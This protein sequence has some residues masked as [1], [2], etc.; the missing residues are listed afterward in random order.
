[1]VSILVCVFNA[2]YLLHYLS[3]FVAFYIDKINHIL[4]VSIMPKKHTQS[5]KMRKRKAKDLD[6]IEEDL[7]PAKAIKLSNQPVDYDLPGDAQYYCIECSRYF[8]DSATLSK[9]RNTKGVFFHF[10][11]LSN[12]LI[13]F[14]AQT[15]VEATQG[16]ALH[17]SRSR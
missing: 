16:C 3:L 2:I 8:I 11:R 15:T 1:M 17:S 9:H 6:Q 13:H 10:S 14:S 5:N 4:V 7:Q 12:N